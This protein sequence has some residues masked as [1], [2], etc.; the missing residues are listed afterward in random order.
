M[1]VAAAPERPPR[2]SSRTGQLYSIDA[3]VGITRP[4]AHLSRSTRCEACLAHRECSLF[5]YHIIL[6]HPHDPP[7]LGMLFAACPARFHAS[8]KQLSFGADASS[9]PTFV[10]DCR[11]AGLQTIALLVRRN[12]CCG[13]RSKNLSG[14]IRYL[15]H[16][17]ETV[18]RCERHNRWFD[19][20]CGAVALSF[21]S[22]HL[23]LLC[24]GSPALGIKG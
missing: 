3:L 17:E 12:P 5:G 23:H 6:M 21:R 15:F 4:A 13:S 24:T 8:P 2:S 18:A 22:P 7:G 9:R 20:R 11:L 16:L 19:H 1:D 10:Y 14:P